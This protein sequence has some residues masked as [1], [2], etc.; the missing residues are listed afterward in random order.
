MQ[1]ISEVNS[2]KVKIVVEFG[3]HNYGKEVDFLYQL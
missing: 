3:I 2:T 1:L